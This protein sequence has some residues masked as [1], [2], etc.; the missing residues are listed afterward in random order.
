MDDL[1]FR[2]IEVGPMANYVYLIG[3]RTTRQAAI[4]DP[5]WQVGDLTKI[6]EEADLEIAHVL[7]THTHPDHVGGDLFGQN[8]EGVAALMEHCKAKVYV[9]KA[10][11]PYFKA[12]PPSDLV[13]TDEHSTLEIGEIRIEF[14]HTPGHTPGSQ[15][16]KLGERLV[17]GDTLFIGSCG[18]CDLPGSNPGDLYDSLQKLKKLDEGTV[19]FPGHNYTPPATSTTI[20]AERAQ[21]PYF[22]FPGKSA[23]LSAMGY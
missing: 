22:S 14:L 19:V 10:E 23:F 6:A 12:I 9:H 11:V 5:A 2:Q 3:S 1:I 21:N 18:R 13:P 20:A 17:S 4:V 7:V 8:I 15:C 16:F